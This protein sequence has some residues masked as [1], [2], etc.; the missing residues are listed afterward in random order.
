MT[1]DVQI[2]PRATSQLLESA[3]W[4]AEN[5]SV[6]QAARWL[7]EIRLAGSIKRAIRIATTQLS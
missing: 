6:A 7:T 4:W 3:S 5:R 2:L 1:R